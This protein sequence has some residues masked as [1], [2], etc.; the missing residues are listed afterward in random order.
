[1]GSCPDT[2]IDPKSS[3]ESGHMIRIDISIWA[4]AHLPLP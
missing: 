2:D 4:T 3:T 1:M